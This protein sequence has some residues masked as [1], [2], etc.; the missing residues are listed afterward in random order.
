MSVQ[1]TYSYSTP[2]G[3]AGGLFDLTDYTIDSRLNEAS[4]GALKFGMGVVQGS[5]PGTNVAIPTSSSTLAK[6]EG[7]AV[8]GFSQQHDLD[9]VIALANSQSVGILRKGRIW[10]RLAEDVA[11]SYGD[12][13]YLSIGD[14]AGLFYD[15][16][17]TTGESPS[18]TTTTIKLT[19]KFIGGAS[20]GFA[21]I[22]LLG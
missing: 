9:G 21:P 11:P 22:D 19:A 8:N 2:K 13:V 5:T 4:D 20:N 6:F 17:Q 12:D 18:T 15:N 14:D 10:V 16:E 3:V 7:I 1:K